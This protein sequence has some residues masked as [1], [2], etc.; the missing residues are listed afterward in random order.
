MENGY[1]YWIFKNVCCFLDGEGEVLNVEEIKINDDYYYVDGWIFWIIKWN[2]IS[3]G[4]IKYYERF[5]NF[6]YI[7]LMVDNSF[8]ID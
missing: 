4:F 6:I 1:N 7:S 3:D 5:W 2:I 8:F